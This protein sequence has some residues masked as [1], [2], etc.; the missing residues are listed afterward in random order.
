M[1]FN[2]RAKS[3]SYFLLSINPLHN[4]FVHHPPQLVSECRLLN[5]ACGARTTPQLAEQLY[6]MDNMK[7]LAGFPKRA[8]SC[9]IPNTPE[10]ELRR[11]ALEHKYVATSFF[12]HL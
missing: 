5:L 6:K 12:I 10:A 9:H 1:P 7:S 11:F 4:T 8:E 3:E 2:S